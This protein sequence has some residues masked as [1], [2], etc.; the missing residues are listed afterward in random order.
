MGLFAAFAAARRGWD[1]TVLEQGRVGESLLAWGRTRFFSPLDMNLPAGLREALPGLPPGDALL[2]GPEMVDR[3]L[4][5][6]SRSPLLYDR[7]H[8]RCRA[9]SVGRAGLSRKDMAGH[10]VRSE[11]P[12]RLLVEAPAG[13]ALPGAS[14]AGELWLEADAV[15]DATGVFC[16]PAWSGIGGLPAP[17]ERAAAGRIL[18]RLGEMEELAAGLAAGRVL[19]LGHGHSA[20]HALLLLGEA[21]SRSPQVTV[22]WAFRS[23][24]LRPLRETPSDPLPGRDRVVRAANALAASPPPWLRVHR[25]SSLHALEMAGDRLRASLIR[26]GASEPLGG[27]DAVAGFTGYRPDLSFLAELALDLSPA[28]EGSRGLHAALAC[29]KDCLSVPQVSPGDL[30]SG[31]PGFHII[32]SKSYGRSGAFLLRDGIRHVEMILDH[33]P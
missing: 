33:A 26:G 11:K 7:V 24:N 15:L 22:D 6:L 21:A 32:G 4:L 1:V 10:P 17:G 27:F 14:T 28:T 9:V 20:A 19:V 25:N 30:A 23:R 5:P 3:V 18:R 8:A 31:E 29:A 2:T 16:N 12:F 13:S